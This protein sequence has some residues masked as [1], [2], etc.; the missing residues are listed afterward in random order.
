MIKAL[1]FAWWNGY[2]AGRFIASV[3]FSQE[4]EGKEIKR[5]RWTVGRVV[6]WIADQGFWRII[7]RRPGKDGRAL[8]N[9]YE[10][11][12]RLL[13]L[14]ATIASKIKGSLPRAFL[15]HKDLRKEPSSVGAASSP[16]PLPDNGGPPASIEQVRANLAQYLKG[17]HPSTGS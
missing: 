8:T 15:Q 13:A 4:R 16:P 2:H 6:Q 3:T 11:T 10:F 5:S 17:Y 9:G 1:F 12:P 7:N 14:L